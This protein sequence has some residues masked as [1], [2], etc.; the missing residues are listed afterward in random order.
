MIVF[1]SRL[2]KL[3]FDPSI[4]LLDQT[5]VSTAR[6]FLAKNFIEAHQKEHGPYSAVLW[7]D[8]DQTFEFMDFLNLLNRFDETNKS[9]GVEILS[10]RYIT[11]DLEEPKVCAFMKAPID[12]V[13]FGYKAILPS[14]QGISEV[15]GF[16]FGFVMMTPKVLV[17]MYEHYGQHMFAFRCVGDKDVGGIIGEDLDWCDK[18]QAIGYKLFFDNDVSIGHYGGVI[19]D[20]VFGVIRND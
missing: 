15:D 17:D 5:N 11:R 3:G 8:S 1:L 18:A 9:D 14:S 10:A 19:D 13:K 7:I 2:N 6:N 20:K 16:G 12:K 4:F